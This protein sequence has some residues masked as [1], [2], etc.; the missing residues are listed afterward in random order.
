MPTPTEQ[1]RGAK[2]MW[3]D[4]LRELERPGPARLLVHP[5]QKA[6]LEKRLAEIKEWCRHADPD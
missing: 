3:R 1:E 2:A 6:A 5:D 4:I